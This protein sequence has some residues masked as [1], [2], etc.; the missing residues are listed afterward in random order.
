MDGQRNRGDPRPFHWRDD[1]SDDADVRRLQALLA[2]RDL[3]RDPLALAQ[4][5]EALATDLLE[6][7]EE[8]LAA[9][10]SRNEA[11]G[12]AVVEPL[13]GS[14]LGAVCGHEIT[15]EWRCAQHMPARGRDTQESPKGIPER[16]WP[17][18]ELEKSL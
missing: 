5:L 8:V 16:A 12:L 3:E 17:S 4:A 18:A 2:L 1:R 7:R 6:V 13:D 11:E 15:F 10:L 9:R 14:C